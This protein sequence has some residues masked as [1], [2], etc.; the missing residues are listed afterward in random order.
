[1]KFES[2]FCY[3]EFNDVKCFNCNQNFNCGIIRYGL[4]FVSSIKNY[5]CLLVVK[6]LNLQ[7]K[8]S[9]LSFWTLIVEKTT[10]VFLQKLKFYIVVFS[11]K[12]RSQ[13]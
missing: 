9:D 5:K 12:F 2:Y 1:M 7:T 11:K 6:I 3:F 8:I 4:F 10:L 13:I